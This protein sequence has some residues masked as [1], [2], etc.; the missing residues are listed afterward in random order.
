MGKGFSWFNSQF[1]VIAIPA[2]LKK[3]DMVNW[4]ML[5]YFHFLLINLNNFR[6]YPIGFFPFSVESC[7]GKEA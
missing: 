3:K 4:Y 7:L 5:G 6:E 2:T 1:S